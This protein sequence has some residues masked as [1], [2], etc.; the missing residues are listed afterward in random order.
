MEL[1]AGSCIRFG[2][3]TFKK[4]PWFLIGVY[5]LFLAV[6]GLIG[7]VLSELGKV[8]P[9]VAFAATIARLAIDMLAGMGIIAIS[10]KAHDDVATITLSDLWHPEPFWYFV[11]AS[12]LAG[13]AVV[14]GIILLIVPG[15]IFALMFG[16]A[17]YLVIERG[18]RPMEALRE[19]RRMTNGHKWMLFRLA[20]LS[21][22]VVLLGV[23]CLIVGVLVAVPV[24]TLASV[25][26][27]RTLQSAAGN[28]AHA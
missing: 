1:T 25:H 20:L 4:R 18:L 23:V 8:G 15:I 17:K 24:V 9:A 26:A 10:L 27:F 28:T 16:F 7:G 21:F 2:W 14:G 13:L 6:V 22:L 12:I 3:E 19:S 5:V 11:G